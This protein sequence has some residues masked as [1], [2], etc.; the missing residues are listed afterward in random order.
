MFVFPPIDFESRIGASSTFFLSTFAMLYVVGGALPK[1]DFLTK[2]DKLIVLTI[3]TVVLSGMWCI[4]VFVLASRHND[5][6]AQMFNNTF[7]VASIAIYIVTN[8]TVL[9]P[10]MLK[11]SRAERVLSDKPEA[12]KEPLVGAFLES[13]CS[14]EAPEARTLPTVGDGFSYAPLGSIFSYG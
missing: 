4:P 11:Q 2:I 14:I 13:P 6:A 12:E 10:A 3:I 8:I 9:V 5:T 1:T 7:A